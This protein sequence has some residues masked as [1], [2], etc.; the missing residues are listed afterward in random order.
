MGANSPSWRYQHTNNRGKSVI[1]DWNSVEHLWAIVWRLKQAFI[2]NDDALKVIERYDQPHTLFYLDPPYLAHTRTDRWK[3]TAY[4]HE[5]D[6]DYHQAL[7]DKLQTIRGMAVIS[8]YPSTL[9]EEQLSG[10][11]RIETTARTT[12]TSKTATETIWLSPAA[13]KGGQGLLWPLDSNHT[14]GKQ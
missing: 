14:G 10:W 2:E 13:T 4:Q 1:K 9:Y 12:N 5:I 11:Q 6:V 7:L 3:E 8:G